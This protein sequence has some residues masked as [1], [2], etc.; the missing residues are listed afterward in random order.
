MNYELNRI[1]CAANRTPDG[2]LILGIRHCDTMMHAARKRSAI[3]DDDWRRSE[4]G[5]VDKFGSF[6]TREEAWQIACNAGQIW[7]FC[8]GQN[9]GSLFQA[10]VKLY[11]E[12][13]Y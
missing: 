3:P 6:H 4:Q 7:R 13:L 11:S 8:G 1:V 10:G 5:F 12:N 9:V 2:I